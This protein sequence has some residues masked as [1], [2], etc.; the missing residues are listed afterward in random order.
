[1]IFENYNPLICCCTRA[2]QALLLQTYV[3]KKKETACLAAQSYPPQSETTCLCEI[4][5]AAWRHILLNGH[6]T[7]QSDGKKID[8]DTL[9]A[10]VELV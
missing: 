4:S 1:M 7:F 3:F 5:P 8:L 6:Y 10:G 2:P 9:L